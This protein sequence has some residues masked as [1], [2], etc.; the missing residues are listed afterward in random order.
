MWSAIC[1]L[2][3]SGVQQL[4]FGRTDR[5]DDGLLQFKR[6]W[7]AEEAK[8]TYYRYGAQST[9]GVKAPR[10]DN[11]GWSRRIM[12]HLPIPILRLIGSIAYRHVA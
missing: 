2:H 5:E 6:G 3:E 10:G 9:A 8:L 1:R 11:R 7:G 4:S 12:R